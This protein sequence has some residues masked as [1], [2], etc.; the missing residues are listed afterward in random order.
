M[1]LIEKYISMKNARIECLEQR[2]SPLLVFR[3]RFA[4]RILNSR[5]GFEILD[6]GGSALEGYTLI[7]D[8]R[9]IAGYEAGIRDVKQ[10]VSIKRSYL[11]KMLEVEEEFK[12]R[13]FTTAAQY[14]PR[15]VLAFFDGTITFRRGD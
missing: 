1:S 7:T 6:E 3:D 12:A 5:L 2:D 10:T 4:K 15:H 13:P 9:R 11:E 8:N 14:L